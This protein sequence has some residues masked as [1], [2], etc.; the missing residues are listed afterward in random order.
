STS[1]LSTVLPIPSMSGTRKTRNPG[2]NGTAFARNAA[3]RARWASNC[4][5]GSTAT[6]PT[7]TRRSQAHRNDRVMSASKRRERREKREERSGKRE[8]RSGGPSS[9]AEAAQRPE[10]RDLL[11][12]AARED[13]DHHRPLTTTSRLRTHD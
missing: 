3:V 4:C 7:S 8:A 10:S 13:K 2:S 11:F 12:Q 6:T 1:R 5:A 9:R